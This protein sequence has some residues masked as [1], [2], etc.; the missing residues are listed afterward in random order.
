MRSVRP[1][2]LTAAC[3]NDCVQFTAFAASLVYHQLGALKPDYGIAMAVVGFFATLGGQLA[4]I[5]LLRALGRRSIIILLMAGLMIV[6]TAVSWVQV[7]DVGHMCVRTCLASRLRT[8]P[9]RGPGN[10]VCC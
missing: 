6:A 3:P 5:A 9:G 4:T 1:S 2:W 10:T 7:R 8:A